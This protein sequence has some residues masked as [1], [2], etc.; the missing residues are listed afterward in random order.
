MDTDEWLMIATL[1]A[2]FPYVAVALGDWV[3]RQKRDRSNDHAPR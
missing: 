2:V 3:M 1:G